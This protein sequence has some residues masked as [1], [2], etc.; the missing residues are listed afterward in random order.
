METNQLGMMRIPVLE[1]LRS[2][3]EISQI[4]LKW[5]KY[6]PPV[7]WEFRCHKYDGIKDFSLRVIEEGFSA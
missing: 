7:P 5:R 4:L 1:K 3:K 2:A 6:Y